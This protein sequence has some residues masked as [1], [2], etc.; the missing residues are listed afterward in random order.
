MRSLPH[1]CV[2]PAGGRPAATADAYD[3]LGASKGDSMATLR[4]RRVEVVAQDP[5]IRVDGDIVT[6][7]ITIPYE[8]LE[9]GP[10]GYAVHVVDYDATSQTMIQPVVVPPDADL[11]A[12]PSERILSD[13][14]YHAINVYALVMRTLH[15]FEFALGRRVAWGTGGHQLKVVPHAFEQANAY[16]A[17]DAEALV[18]GYVRAGR[19]TTYFGLS[20]DIIVHETTHALLD[21]LRDGFTEPSSPD[22]AALHEALADIV[23]LLS[24]FSLPEVLLPFVDRLPNEPE[25]SRRARP[26][27]RENLLDKSVVTRER[28]RRTVLFGLADELRDETGD[29]RVNALRRSVLIEPATDLLDQW[30]FEEPHRRGEVLVAAILN[31]FIDAWADRIE[32]VRSP[33]SRL[34]SRERV[35]EEGATIADLLLTMAIRAIDY[36]PPIHIEFGDYLSALLTADREVRG[37][38]SRY[39]LRR[40]LL[41]SCASYGIRPATDAADGSWTPPSARLARS[42][43]HVSSLQNDRTEMFRLI[44]ANRRALRLE[45]EAFTRVVSLRPAFRVA[46]EDG[47][48]VRETVVECTQ[49]L[50]LQASELA[51]YR[52]AVPEGME[53]DHEIVFRGGSTL[54]LDEYGDLKF[55]VYN[56]IPARTGMS[57]ERR[58]RWQRRLDYL[59][60][61]GFLDQGASLTRGLPSLHRERAMGAGRST[62][63][64]TGTVPT[65]REE[66]WT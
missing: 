21:G 1:W 3:A 24:V 40:R 65:D 20:H 44:W 30:E 28:L 9:P 13:P 47:F 39:E 22:Q 17:E 2:G 11:P 36:T 62:R 32:G 53:A 29:A 41:A 51:D 45:P 18:F 64:S 55:E 57:V 60:D 37:D 34:V 56:P 15:R 5:S 66:A 19:A 7:W 38:D 54:I 27:A 16:Y 42:G 14:A 58:R 43:A 8:D 31:A 35:A 52:L 49:Y 63:R 25:G 23:A 46:P 4:M 48:H 50:K 61:N 12:P 10:M 6:A 59:W 26:A 33:D